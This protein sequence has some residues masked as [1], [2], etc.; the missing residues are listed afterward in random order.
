MIRKITATTV[1]MLAILGSGVSSA[2]EL[3]GVTVTAKQPVRIGAEARAVGTCGDAVVSKLLPNYTTPVRVVVPNIE[4]SRGHNF[5]VLEAAPRF[6]VELTARY[7]RTGELL[8]TASCTVS[9]RGEVK[10][11]TIKLK[12]G[13]LLAGLTPRDIRFAMLAR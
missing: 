5:I 11:M 4:A 3:A 6:D 10:A 8:A 1:A 13:S 12:N 9:R 7:S 2:D